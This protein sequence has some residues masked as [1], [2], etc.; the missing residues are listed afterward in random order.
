MMNVKAKIE[1]IEKMLK[2]L[3]DKLESKGGELVADADCVLDALS[4]LES[5]FS[6]HSEALSDQVKS[7]LS[8]QA[9]QENRVT[10]SYA[11]D[12]QQQITQR[13]LWISSLKRQKSGG[14]LTS[15]PGLPADAIS[16][17]DQKIEEFQREI[18]ELG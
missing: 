17:I 15:R 10:P 11:R 12:I 8:Q 18:R 9:K 16:E 2:Q 3:R 6:E 14:V 7:F 5:E 4:L 1:P 13:E